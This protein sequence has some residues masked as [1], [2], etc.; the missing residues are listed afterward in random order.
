MR[1]R[2]LLTEVGLAYRMVN[3]KG[4]VLNNNLKIDYTNSSIRLDNAIE[5]SKKYLIDSIGISEL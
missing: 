4:N 3:E 2:D 1:I 5:T